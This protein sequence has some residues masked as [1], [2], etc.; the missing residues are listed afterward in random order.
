M[1]KRAFLYMTKAKGAR[2]NT[3]MKTMPQRILSYLPTKSSSDS[4]IN[5]TNCGIQKSAS[6]KNIIIETCMVI[7][8]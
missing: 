4:N 7:T 1:L 8:E 2:G 6:S 5:C 3:H